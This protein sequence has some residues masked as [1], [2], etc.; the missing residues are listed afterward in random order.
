MNGEVI[1]ITEQIPFDI[2][3]SWQWVRLRTL[4]N[5]TTGASFKKEEASA[6]SDNKVRILRGGNIQPFRLQF[7]G[8]DIFINK[9][10]VNENILL[11]KNDLVTPAVTSLENICKMA[12]I[13]QDYDD[14]SMG[15]FVFIIRGFYNNNSLAHYLQCVFSTPTTIEFVRSITNKSG[16]AFYNIGK[17]RLSNTLIPIP[18]FNEIIRITTKLNSLFQSLN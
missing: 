10:L 6:Q 9:E 1:D 11:R 8:D 7:K 16:Q 13:E 2:P 3:A 4:C 17:E 12:L 15:G 14:V 18:P 5:I